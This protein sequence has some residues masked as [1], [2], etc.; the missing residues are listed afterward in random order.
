MHDQQV[1]ARP[2]LDALALN[3]SFIAQQLVGGT[4][5]GKIHLAIAKPTP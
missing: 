5:A 1:P 4:E 3:L 2:V